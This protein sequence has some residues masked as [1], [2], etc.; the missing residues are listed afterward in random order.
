MATGYYPVYPQGPV[1]VEQDGYPQVGPPTCAAEP[2]PGYYETHAGYYEQGYPPVGPVVWDPVTQEYQQ[3]MLPAGPQRLMLQ[4]GTYAT[5][6][7]EMLQYQDGARDSGYG[8][9][10]TSS[11]EATGGNRAVA[12]LHSPRCSSCFS[13]HSDSLSVNVPR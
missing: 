12:Q 10:Y 8:G 5:H 4:D 9:Y 13:F 6:S 2:H 11:S 1:Y 3:Q 7:A